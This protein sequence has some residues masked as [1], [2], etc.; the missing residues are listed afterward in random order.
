MVTG[1]HQFITDNNG[2]PLSVV[3]PIQQYNEIIEIV[4]QYNRESKF[5]PTPEEMES[6]EI[7]NQQII[8]GK[9]ISSM[10]LSKRLKDKY[11]S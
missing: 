2:T 11:G 7:S 3:I 10:D 5:K 8:E 6:L 1:N 4:E 9:T